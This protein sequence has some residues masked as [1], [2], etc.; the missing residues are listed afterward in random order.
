M[1]S[2]LDKVAV[3]ELHAANCAAAT[4]ASS[5]RNINFRRHRGLL[6]LAILVFNRF[7]LPSFLPVSVGLH[8]RLGVVAWDVLLGP[9]AVIADGDGL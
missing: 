8:W 3:E 7:C 4:M 9:P 5:L 2:S 6:M 1:L